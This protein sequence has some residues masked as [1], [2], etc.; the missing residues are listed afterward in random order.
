MAPSKAIDDTLRRTTK[1]LKLKVQSKSKILRSV[2][3]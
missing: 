2:L 3:S 1:N